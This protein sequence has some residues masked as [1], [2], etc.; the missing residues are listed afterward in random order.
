[1]KTNCLFNLGLMFFL[2]PHFIHTAVHSWRKPNIHV[3][4]SSFLQEKHI[5]TNHDR[6]KD[7]VGA[8][9]KGGH[10]GG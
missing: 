6:I 8:G 2:Y 9:L 10:L 4:L 3:F 5:C 7:Q 1:M